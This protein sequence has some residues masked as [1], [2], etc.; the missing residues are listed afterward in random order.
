VCAPAPAARWATAL[1]VGATLLLFYR[2]FRLIDLHAVNL[3]YFDQF[4]FYEAFKGQTDAWTVFRWQH[5][6]HRQGLAFLGTWLIAEA[7]DWN[8]RVDAFYV[9]ALIGIATLLALWLRRRL[10][11]PFRPTDVAIPLL[12]TTP[13][14]YGI[15]I[16]TPNASHS[17][18]PLVLLMLHALAW[19]SRR[20]SLRYVAIAVIGFLA[21]HT[22]FGFF[23]GVLTPVLLAIAGL[24]DAREGGRARAVLPLACAVASLSAIAVFFTGYTFRGGIDRIAAP[25]LEQVP[26]YLR[27]TA[28]MF[29]NV[30]GVKGLGALP[31]GVGGLVLAGVAALALEQLG[32]VLRSRREAAAS[33]VL[34]SLTSFTLVYCAATAIGRIHLGLAGAQSSRYVPLVAPALLAVL[35]RLQFVERPKRRATLLAA[36]VLVLLAATFPMRER[37]ARF[38]EHLSRGKRAWIE[39]YLATDSVE[40]ANRVAR[41]KLE[42]RPDPDHP[43]EESLAYLRAHRLNFFAE[44]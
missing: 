20:R 3:L 11:G 33:F 25:S 18:G 27:Y 28:L 8:T 6:P 43:L 5:G 14:Q 35:L 26:D 40:E 17:A 4:G 9:G 31:S 23:L 37:E 19:T 41:L 39:T 38:M 36:S 29:A 12:L 42:F 44:R 34:L 1:V 16:H 10:A 22:G 15:F 24:R 13:A 2:L 30:L 32:T 7:T 21:I